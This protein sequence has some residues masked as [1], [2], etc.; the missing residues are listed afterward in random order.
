MPVSLTLKCSVTRSAVVLLLQPHAQHDFAVRREL[1][2]V[3]DHV[4]QHLPEAPGIADQQ[5]RNVGGDVVGELERL[6]RRRGARARV[7]ASPTVSRRSNGLRSSSSRRASIF[8]KSRMSLMT[9]EQRVGRRLHGR[10]VLPLFGREPR[11]QRERRHADDGVE[12]RADLVAHVRQKRALGVGGRSPR[13]ASRLS[14]SSTSCAEP[15]GLI[16]ELAVRHLEIRAYRCSV[17]SAALRSVMS[18]AAA[19]TTCCSRNGA[20]RPEQPAHAFRPCGG[21]GSR[22]RPP[23]APCDQLPRLLRASPRDRPDERNPGT[24]GTS[25]SSVGPSEHAL[26]HRIDPL[27]V[28]VEAGD[29]EHV[30][31]QAEEAIELVLRAP[32]IDEHAD[33]VADRREQSRASPRRVRAPRG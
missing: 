29:A 7:T 16:V 12:R 6:F 1:D 9:L 25:S 5:L 8:E 30:E 27:E 15:R 24:A 21:T 28:A 32:P 31:R 4:E 22:S 3:A 23:R 18:C 2:G 33:L 17:S 14:S 10:Q 11:L 13:G 26:P 19:Y 20:D